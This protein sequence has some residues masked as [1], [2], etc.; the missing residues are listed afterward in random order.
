MRFNLPDSARE[1]NE[2]QTDPAG[3][4]PIGTAMLG[5]VVED[6]RLVNR[7]IQATGAQLSHV[8]RLYELPLT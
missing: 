3:E 1:P 7:M 8:F 4:T 5:W 2:D 6:D